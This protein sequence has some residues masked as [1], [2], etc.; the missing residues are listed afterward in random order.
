[1][2]GPVSI[3]G[4]STIALTPNS[5]TPSSRADLAEPVTFAEAVEVGDRVAVALDRLPRLFRAH[6][7]HPTPACQTAD[8]LTPC[9]DPRRAEARRRPLRLR[10]V[11]GAPRGAREAR[12]AR[13][14]DRDL[15]PPARRS[16]TSSPGSA[17]ASPSS[18]AP[19]TATRSRSATAARPPS[20]TPPPPAWSASAPLHLSYGE[21]SAKFAK[22][23]AAAPVPRRPDRGRGRAG[24]RARA[25]RRPGADALAWAHNE[26]STGVV[27]AGRAPG[28]RRR[29]AGADRRHLGRRRAAARR[30]RRPTPTTSPRRRRSAPTAASGWR[31]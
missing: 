6:A 16:R 9:P 24:R 14:R 8:E 13:R 4:G 1:M 23:T 2:C 27:V 19:P 15:A 29:R 20:G 17:A 12:R 25:G 3:P 7:E 30:R 21:F 31:C 26:T 18:S 10:A 5:V 22:V 28:R 11:E